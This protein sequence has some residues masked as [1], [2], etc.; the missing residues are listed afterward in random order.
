MAGGEHADARAVE[1]SG[2][3][4]AAGGATYGHGTCRCRGCRAAEKGLNP[5]PKAGG[6]LQQRSTQV[7]LLQILPTRRKP[8]EQRKT[9]EVIEGENLVLGGFETH[10]PPAQTHAHA[11][12]PT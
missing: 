4:K 11:R 2:R 5:R 6:P 10:A 7:R 9:L 1:V 3:L 12:L 8:E